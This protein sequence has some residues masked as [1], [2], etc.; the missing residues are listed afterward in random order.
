MAIHVAAAFVTLLT[1]VGLT[2]PAL[3]TASQ[4]TPAAPPTDPLL[5][6]YVE[7][8][9]REWPGE[10]A[11]QA[12]TGESLTLLADAVGS[13]AE[14]KQLSSPQVRL[15]VEQLRRQTAEY[16]VGTPGTLEQSKRLR[17]TFATAAELVASLVDRA[18]LEQQPVDPRLSALGRAA[19]S[20]D[21][22]ML[23]RRQPD[24][25]ERFFHHAGEALRRIDTAGELGRWR[26]PESFATRHDR[27]S[28]ARQVVR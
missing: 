5:R 20:L 6:T 15:A 12:L 25:I 23:L 18:G 27:C 17:R 3:A 7:H 21:D 19:D 9:A 26:E 22:E 1:I 4:Q 14:R 10:S 2:V 16:Q 28:V 8:V 24:V 13:V 11:Q